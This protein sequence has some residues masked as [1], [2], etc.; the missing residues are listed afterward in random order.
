MNS[1]THGQ[2]VK[3]G[4]LALCM[5]VK[6][7]EKNLR[8]YLPEHTDCIDELIIIDTGSEDD[9]IKIAEEYGAKV[10][11]LPWESDFAKLKNAA[12]SYVKS[13]WMLILDADEKVSNRL[14]EE[15]RA[16]ISGS[17]ECSG[18]YMPRKNYYFGRWLKYGGNYPDYQLKLFRKGKVLYRHPPIHPKI[19]IDG[20][21]G[22]LKNALEHF[23]Y[24]KVEDYL[25]K[26]DLYTSGDA[27]YLKQKNMKV[28][29]ANSVRWIVIK[30]SIRFLKRYFI[31]GG[32][33]NG[34]PG[35]FAC[36]FDAL[37]YPVK[38]FKLWQLYK[39][40]K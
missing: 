33:L 13:E 26:F 11:E 30:P 29:F 23:P 15:M 24:E 12:A 21:I 28:N 18:F 25:R 6:N 5:I 10:Y 3:K 20:K 4:T 14:K 27:S 34:M 22:Y 8:K 32:F 1:E 35:I 31:K 40:E 38:Y 7:E 17:S 37:N 19:V 9:T 2:I 16:V 39:N 36:I